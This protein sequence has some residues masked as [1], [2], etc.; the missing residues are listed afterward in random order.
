MVLRD[1]R[2]AFPGEMSRQGLYGGIGLV[3]CIVVSRFDYSRMRE[4]RYGF[5]ALLIVINLFVYAMPAGGAIEGLGGAH[6]WIPFPFFQF[7]SSE[8]GKLLLILALSAIMVER[9]RKPQSGLAHDDPHAAVGPAPC[10][11]RDG[12]AGPGDRPGVRDHRRVGA[13]LR[14]HRLEAAGGARQPGAGGRRARP[15]GGARPRGQRPA[16]LPE[17]AA[18]HVRQSAEGVRGQRHHLLPAPAG[19]DRHRRRPEDR[20]G[21]QG[22]LTDRGPVRAGRQRGLHL[23]LARRLLRLCRSSP[24]AGA[25]RADDLA[26]ITDHDDGQEPLRNAHRRR[27]SGHA[28][29]PG[30]SSTWA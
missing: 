26:H 27:H 20:S 14:R 6:R 19:S 2:G 3:A 29:V 17:A 10:G 5:Y 9:S 22:R 4:Y 1:M 24:G 28:D 30:F 25:V 23:R 21:D 16:R 8:F 18:D 13:V 12:P 15:R 7:Q 11:D